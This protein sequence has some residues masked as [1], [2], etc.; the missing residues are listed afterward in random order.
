MPCPL[1]FN[2]S[3]SLDSAEETQFGASASVLQGV[4]NVLESMR[5]TITSSA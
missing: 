2:P 1:A 5:R 3:A 4:T